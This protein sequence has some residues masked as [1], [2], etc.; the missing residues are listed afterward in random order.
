LGS[1]GDHTGWGSAAVLFQ[2]E[3]A[4]EGV[5]DRL[6]PLADTSD[7]AEAGRFVLAVR[8]YQVGAEPVGDEGFELLRSAP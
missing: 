6:D 4:F 8:P 2:A 7:L 3:L 5:D 1:A